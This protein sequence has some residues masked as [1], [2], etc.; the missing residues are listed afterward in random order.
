VR[1]YALLLAPGANRVYGRAAPALGRAELSLI[2]EF[3]LAG[4]LSDLHE[5][6]MGG[7]AYLTFEASGLDADDIAVLSNLSAV[8]ALFERDGPQL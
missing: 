8:F 7:V 1:R 4:R 6:Q 3:G 2:N 5:E